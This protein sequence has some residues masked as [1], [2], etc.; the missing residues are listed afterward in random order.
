VPGRRWIRRRCHAPAGLFAIGSLFTLTWVAG[1]IDVLDGGPLPDAYVDDP[2]LFWLIRLLD[3]A[4][5]LP[6]VFITAVGL[7]RQA[8]WASK[9]AAILAGFG[10]LLAGS[11]A[12]MAA[13]MVARDDPSASPAMLAATAAITAGLA[14]TFVRLIRVAS[15]AAEAGDAGA[16]PAGEV[17]PPGGPA[18]D[19]RSVPAPPAAAH[20]G[21]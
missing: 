12:G 9:L 5:V 21:R 6:V 1:I 3:L 8:A 14:L 11:V 15:R 18:R 19:G 13:V 7:V 17:M 10:T 4:F 2:T 20:R 16:R